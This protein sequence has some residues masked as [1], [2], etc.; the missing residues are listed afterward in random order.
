MLS[1]A[2]NPGF[3][4][5]FRF[6]W[7]VLALTAAALIGLTFASGKAPAAHA[8]GWIALDGGR[9]GAY[10]WSVK[11][12]S[13][14]SP[15]LLVGIKK[16]LGPF[17]FQRG[18]YRNCA[19]SSGRLAAT[20]PPL[21]V[22]GAAGTGLRPRLT[23]VGLMV[24]PAVRRVRILLSDGSR[25]TLPLERLSSKQAR[26]SRA[27]SFRY[28]AF[29]VRGQWCPERLVAQSATGRTLWEGG[30]DSQSCAAEH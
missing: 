8:S 2:K 21:I 26:R 10:Q 27:G 12:K 14:T 20:E 4:S 3:G 1:Y 25:T 24:S 17:S 18:R 23:A 5:R 7:G 30:A 15:C 16:Q 19:G 29:S 22:R 13:S 28:A 9:L 6:A 11:A